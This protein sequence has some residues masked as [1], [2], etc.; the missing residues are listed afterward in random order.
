MT[1]HSTQTAREEIWPSS[2]NK[3]KQTGKSERNK[4]KIMKIF[5]GKM[6]NREIAAE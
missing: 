4:P 3:K 1:I 2:R 6:R 5:I